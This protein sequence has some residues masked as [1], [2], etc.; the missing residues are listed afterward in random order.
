MHI[1]VFIIPAGVYY[2]QKE[3]ERIEKAPASFYL[4]LQRSLSPEITSCH[5]DIGLAGLVGIHNPSSGAHSHR[6]RESEKNQFLS[7]F[8]HWFWSIAKALHLQKSST[9]TFLLLW[10]IT[11]IIVSSTLSSWN[12]KRAKQNDAII[13]HGAETAKKDKI[14][15][16][17]R[18]MYCVIKLAGVTFHVMPRPHDAL[19]APLSNKIKRRCKTD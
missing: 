4:W 13:N 6:E 15:T 17:L 14:V 9:I 1:W 16:S 3:R 11:K 7:T 12:E 5:S 8:H 2:M 18:V 10:P 19:P